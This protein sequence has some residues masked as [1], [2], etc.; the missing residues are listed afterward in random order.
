MIFFSQ[1]NPRSKLAKVSI[2]LIFPQNQPPLGEGKVKPKIISET[3]NIHNYI[4]LYITAKSQIFDEM[5][6]ISL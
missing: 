1:K 4:I 5:S 6:N 3:F 2:K